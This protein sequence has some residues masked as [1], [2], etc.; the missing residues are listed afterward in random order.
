MEKKLILMVG[1]PRSGK[2]T[3]AKQQGFPIVNPDAIRLALHGKRF[4]PS[5]EPTVWATAR[6]MVEALFLAGHE[7]VIVDATHV[8]DKRRKIWYSQYANIEYKIMPTSPQECVN[9]AEAE[10]DGEI[11]PIIA[12]MA[13]DWDLDRPWSPN[14]EL[15]HEFTS[16]MS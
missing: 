6:L 9:R 13:M 2:S 5:A 4:I 3:W 8:T 15:G 7:T 14:E 16:K 10:Q 1:L 11:I 12:R